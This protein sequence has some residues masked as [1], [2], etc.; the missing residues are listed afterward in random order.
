VDELPQPVWS[1][2][3]N[4]IGVE[5]RC[6]VLSDGRRIIEA[7]SVEQLLAA[8]ADPEVDNDDAGLEAFA[9]WRAGVSS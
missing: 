5:V 1:G 6:H 2:A 8:M 3:F 7:D 9:R 4:V